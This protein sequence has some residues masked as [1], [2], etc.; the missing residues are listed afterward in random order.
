MA[1]SAVAKV[2]CTTREAA[3]RLGISLRT[4]Q[5]WVE[6]GLLTAWK[7]TGGHRRIALESVERLIARPPS[8]PGRTPAAERRLRIL[9]VED[10][11]LT[12]ELYL[13]VISRW[14]MAPRVTAAANGFE[15]LVRMGQQAPDV[16]ITDLDMPG[17]DGFEMLRSLAGLPGLGGVVPLVIT[18]L[19]PAQI[20]ERGALPPG[21]PVLQ[22]PVAFPALLGV[23][24]AIAEG[25]AARPA[26]AA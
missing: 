16:L 21:V 13:A 2:F 20:A 8:E 4:A 10:D 18:A 24:A 11:Q 1:R 23:V 15:G 12:R 9:V 26:A 3:E 19:S 14:P 17:M 5:L 25:L 6:S 22:K 7:T